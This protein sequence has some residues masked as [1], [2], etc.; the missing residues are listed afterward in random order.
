[1]S[2]ETLSLSTLPFFS[3]FFWG[4]GGGR[5]QKEDRGTDSFPCIFLPGSF[6]LLPSYH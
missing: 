1:M 4:G 5:G 6:S 2:G 3:F